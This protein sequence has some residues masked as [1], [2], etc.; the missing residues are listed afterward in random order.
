VLADY[1]RVRYGFSPNTPVY[2]FSGDNP[3]S[4]V[5]M[6][7]TEPGT[8]VVSLGTSDTVFAATR[9][10]CVDPRG[11]GHVFGNPTGGFMSL[12]CFANGSLSRERVAERFGMNWE[13]FSRAILDET[14][15]GNESNLMLPF[16]VP[17]M[18]PRLTDPEVQLFGSEGFVAWKEPAKMARAVVE[19]Q[20]LGMQRYSA[21]MAERP[22]RLLVTGGGARN[23]G[24]R[25][26]LADVFDA[27]V[28]TLPAGNSSALGAALRAAE[29]HTGRALAELSEA[30]VAMDTVPAAKPDPRAR[31]AYAE[32]RAR[33]EPLLAALERVSI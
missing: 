10:P 28:F 30:F 6:G 4:L 13:E 12:V 23:A 17:E 32:L 2:A 9:E 24:I 8:L 5:G 22:G 18:T 19:A 3:S 7:A 14:G 16:F 1:F 11:Y 26:V 31:G 33:R 15:P 20:A 29:A 27:E 21:Y 25:Q